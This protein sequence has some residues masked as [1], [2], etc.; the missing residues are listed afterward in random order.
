VS[1]P[2]TF[3]TIKGIQASGDRALARSASERYLEGVRDVY[4]YSGTVFKLYA[5]IK[6]SASYILASRTGKK[7]GTLRPVV[8]SGMSLTGNH[9]SPG[10]DESGSALKA[11]GGSDNLAKDAFVGWTGLGP[12]TILIEHIIGIQ[13]NSPRGTIDWDLRR[14]DRNGIANLNLGQAGTLSLVADARASST[15][16]TRVCITG[17]ISKAIT[18]YITIGGKRVKQVVGPGAVQVCANTASL[19]VA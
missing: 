3:A 19:P 12:I 18:V 14:T 7:E 13:A 4:D 17:N 10:T 15:V 2:S 6:Q 16:D 11:A 8:L 5:P 9:V 1:A